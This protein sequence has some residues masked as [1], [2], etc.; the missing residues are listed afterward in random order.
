MGDVDTRPAAV[1]KASVADEASANVVAANPSDPYLREAQTFPRLSAE[2]IARAPAFGAVKD[3]S[4]GAV[5]FERGNRTVDF[6]MTVD[7]R[8]AAVVA[9][10]VLADPAP[11]RDR[12][13]RVTGAD[14]LTCDHP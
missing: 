13:D 3:L 9:A 14:L 11:Y 1:M 4:A 8:D 10:T 5:L 12:D 7:A 6:F 2:Q